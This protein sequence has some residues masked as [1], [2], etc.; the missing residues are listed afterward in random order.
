MRQINWNE[1]SKRP[2][3]LLEWVQHGNS[4][5]IYQEGKAVAEL[6]PFKSPQKP[7]WK[8]PLKR[9]KLSVKSMS[10]EILHDRDERV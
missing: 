10:A 8:R 4:L 3:E 9:L 6:V 1:L 5:R 2:A 7:A